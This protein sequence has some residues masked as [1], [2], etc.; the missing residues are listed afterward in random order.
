MATQ[1]DIMPDTITPQS[2]QETPVPNAPVEAP[3]T[4][5]PGISEPAPDY[6][7]PDTAPSETPLP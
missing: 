4:D 5:L 2:P 3:N 1:P 6:D 7:Q